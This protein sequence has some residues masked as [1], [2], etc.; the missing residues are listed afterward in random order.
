MA[1][2]SSFA[3][4]TYPEAQYSTPSARARIRDL[5]GPNPS[6][7]DRERVAKYMSRSLRAGP[8]D[9]CRELVS[10]AVQ[11]ENCDACDSY[12]RCYEAR[13]CAKESK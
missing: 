7:A 10:K 2:S 8:I 3:E 13:K 1:G 11:F 9:T 5:L 6:Y 4:T 12:D